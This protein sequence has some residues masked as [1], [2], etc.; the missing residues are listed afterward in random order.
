MSARP[1]SSPRAIP[2]APTRPD[3]AVLAAL[4]DLR[5]AIT[6]LASGPDPAV[7]AGLES[8]R[9]ATTALSTRVDALADANSSFRSVLNERLDEYAETV[10]RVLKGVSTDV[11][12]YRR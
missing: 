1:D 2:G 10:L 8:L 3:P 4:E 7:A 12:E 6:G 11:E 9:S 5:S